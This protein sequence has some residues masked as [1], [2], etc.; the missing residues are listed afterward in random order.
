MGHDYRTKTSIGMSAFVY[1]YFAGRTP[2]VFVGFFII[3]IAQRALAERCLLIP[4]AGGLILFLI[5]LG[6]LTMINSVYSSIIINLIRL[7]PI[8]LFIQYWALKRV[9]SVDHQRNNSSNEK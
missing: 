9:V 7:L 3:G 4:S 5:L 1:L 8:A 6:P 2:A